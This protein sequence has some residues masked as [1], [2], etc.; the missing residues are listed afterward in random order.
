MALY[1]VQHGKSLPKDQ[2]PDQGLS[3]E[4]K[5]ETEMIAKTAKEKGVTVSQI[6]HSVKTRAR[7]TA[8]ILA[9]ALAPNQGVQEISGIKPMDNVAEAAANLD[10]SENV[11]LIGHLPFM[12][13]MTAFLVTGSIDKP[14]FKFQNS[15]IVC[16][17]KDPDT[18]AWVILWVLLPKIA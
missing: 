6:R 13:R 10:P 11:M 8:E 2:D 16:L 7:Q 5:A 1:L 9:Q 12:E 3:E 4:G 17:D 14:I 18:Q 15:G